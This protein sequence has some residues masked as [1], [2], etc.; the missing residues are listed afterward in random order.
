MG[1][2]KII[3]YLPEPLLP[4]DDDPDLKDERPAPLPDNPD[5]FSL[6][7]IPVASLLPYPTDASR[8]DTDIFS[9]IESDDESHTL[10]ALPCLIF[11]GIPPSIRTDNS[12]GL[13]PLYDSSRYGVINNVS[14]SLSISITLLIKISSAKAILKE[15][16]K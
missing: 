1:V 9:F 7:L 15:H 10:T 16:I 12:S 8:P 14:V 11:D 3:P 4:P 2:L 13:F 6:D 5:L